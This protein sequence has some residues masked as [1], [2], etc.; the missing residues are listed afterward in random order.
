MAQAAG[1]T[2]GLAGGD[3]QDGAHP[4]PSGEDRIAHRLV[5]VRG[6]FGFRGKVAVQR[7]VDERAF[8]LEIVLDVHIGSVL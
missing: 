6:K 2:R 4:L 5:E 8:F 3:H 7:P 1:L